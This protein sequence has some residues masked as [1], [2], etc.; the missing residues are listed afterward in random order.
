VTWK[1]GVEV[2]RILEAIRLSAVQNTT[3]SIEEV[4]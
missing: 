3:I 2:I 1:D 4:S